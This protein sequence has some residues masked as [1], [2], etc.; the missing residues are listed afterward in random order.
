MIA[1]E[2]TPVSTLES[3]WVLLP[4]LLHMSHL[5]SMKFRRGGDTSNNEAFV[6]VHL[7]ESLIDCDL[8]TTGIVNPPYSTIVPPALTCISYNAVRLTFPLPV[9]EDARRTDWA[10]GERMLLRSLIVC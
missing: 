9:A 5:P 8:Y 4:M 3:S 2:S 10:R 6:R 1:L 7:T